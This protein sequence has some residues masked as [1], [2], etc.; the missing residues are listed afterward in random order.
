MQ[1]YPL[2]T[3]GKLLNGAGAGGA[4]GAGRPSSP[5]NGRQG[6]AALF[7]PPSPLTPHSILK[8]YRKN[9]KKKRGVRRRKAA[10]PCRSAHL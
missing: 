8:N 6:M 5:P 4:G 1:I 10:K 2:A 9:R 7:K 3:G